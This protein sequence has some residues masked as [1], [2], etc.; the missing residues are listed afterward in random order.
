MNYQPINDFSKDAVEKLKK[1]RDDVVATA[2]ALKLV[3]GGGSGSGGGNIQVPNYNEVNSNNK[4]AITG[5]KYIAE[6]EM[7]KGQNG[8]VAVPFPGRGASSSGSETQYG[9]VT[10]TTINN[11]KNNNITV[12]GDAYFGDDWE[13]ETRGPQSKKSDDFL[14]LLTSYS[15][16][17]YTGEWGNT[18]KLAGLHEKELVLNQTD[19]A[20]ILDA[21]SLIRQMTLGTAQLSMGLGTIGAGL[22]NLNI[23]L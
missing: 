16:G 17:G 22:N 8:S 10:P 3:G 14:D 7:K 2:E 11:E 23:E 6:E 20:N 5:S 19:T 12:N 4:W 15:S 18:A 21:V 1:V 9:D 13:P